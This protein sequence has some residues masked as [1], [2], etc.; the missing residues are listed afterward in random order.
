MKL[1]KIEIVNY[2]KDTLAELVRIRML[3]EKIVYKNENQRP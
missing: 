1:P 3:L 2:E